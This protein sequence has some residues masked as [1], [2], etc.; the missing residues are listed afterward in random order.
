MRSVSVEPRRWLASDGTELHGFS[1]GQGPIILLVNG[2]G[3]SW[4][5]WNRQLAHFGDRYRLIG[6]EYRG[7]YRD[8]APAHVGD[9]GRH[10]EDAFEVLEQEGVDR[11]AVVAWSFGV[12]VALELFRRAPQRFASLVF[13]N[14]AANVQWA[15][16]SAGLRRLYPGLL[17]VGVRASGVLPVTGSSWL[18]SPEAFAW[19]RR[20]GLLGGELD[21]ETYARVAE[22]LTEL[23]V[24]RY[25]ESLRVFSSHDASDVLARVDVPALVIGSDRDPLVSRAGVERLVQGIAGA[26][27]LQIPGATHFVMLDHAQHVNLRIEKFFGETGY[28]PQVGRVA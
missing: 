12:P 19:G 25:L 22:R 4:Q 10:A 11:A 27:Y 21:Q 3:P 2:L 26:Q 20:L 15:A 6:W 13:L 16:P 8:E 14:G 1:H 7:L 24:R 9:P 28:A 23:D 17:R 5:V 18:A